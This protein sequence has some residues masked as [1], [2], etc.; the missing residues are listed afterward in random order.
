MCIFSWLKI[1]IPHLIHIYPLPNIWKMKNKISINGEPFNNLNQV[2]SRDKSNSFRKKPL[3][4]DR[5]QSVNQ[6]TCTVLLPFELKDPLFL[7]NITH[8]TGLHQEHCINTPS[9]LKELEANTLIKRCYCNMES[10]NHQNLKVS[11]IQ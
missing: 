2:Q 8:F 9:L 6:D 5:F 7:F 10:I 3:K 4:T 11:F 1:K